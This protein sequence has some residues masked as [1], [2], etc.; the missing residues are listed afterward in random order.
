MALYRDLY[1]L[2]LEDEPQ[3]PVTS[4]TPRTKPQL[5][6]GG[7]V[8]KHEPA[9][10]KA[11]HGDEASRREQERDRMQIHHVGAGYYYPNNT[12]DKSVYWWDGNRFQMLDPQEASTTRERLVTGVPGYKGPPT[13]PSAAEKAVPA[14]YHI[15]S[16]ADGNFRQWGQGDDARVHER[17]TASVKEI[18]NYLNERAPSRNLEAAN[19]EQKVAN[20]LKTYLNIR[21]TTSQLSRNESID[22]LRESLAH[23]AEKYGIMRFGGEEKGGL[24]VA[25]YPDRRAALPMDIEDA[26]LHQPFGG[27]DSD[28]SV[29]IAGALETVYGMALP[30]TRKSGG[31]PQAKAYR[32]YVGG[33]Q[34]TEVVVGG[35]TEAQKKQ[36]D[37]EF[38]T[39]VVFG[40]EDHGPNRVAVIYHP[41]LLDKDDTPLAWPSVKKMPIYEHFHQMRLSQLRAK[42]G[43]KGTRFLTEDD[44][45]IQAE[46][47]TAEELLKKKLA[48]EKV[49]SIIGL[50]KSGK[51]TVYLPTTAAWVDATNSF[52]NLFGNLRA[53]HLCGPDIQDRIQ[54]FI[55]GTLVPFKFTKPYTDER[56][57]EWDDQ[58]VT[59]IL[60]MLDDDSH[61]RTARS[62]ITEHLS[63][64]RQMKLENLVAIPT[65]HDAK[66]DLLA[67]DGRAK[68]G[69]QHR[70]KGIDVQV[71]LDENVDMVERLSA[72]RVYDAVKAI[73][74]KVGLGAAN[75]GDNR[76]KSSVMRAVDFVKSDGKTGYLTAWEL[77]EK[78]LDFINGTYD[79]LWGYTP[80][81]QDARKKIDEFI[82]GVFGDTLLQ[83]TGF[84]P[85]AK[86]DPINPEPYLKERQSAIAAL[87]SSWNS[88]A[89]LVYN[90]LN[91][92]DAKPPLEPK[93]RVVGVDPDG[94][95]R[96]VR[97][98]MPTYRAYE[99]SYQD[100]MRHCDE[101]YQEAWGLYNEA[102]EAMT[103]ALD[104]TTVFQD[105]ALNAYEPRGG[106]IELDITGETPEWQKGSARKNHKRWV[107]T[108]TNGGLIDDEGTTPTVMK[109]NPKLI[110]D[111][112]SKLPVAQAKG[113]RGRK[114]KNKFLMRSGGPK[115][116]DTLLGET[117][118]TKIF[119]G[120]QYG[121]RNTQQDSPKASGLGPI[122]SRL[123][124]QNA[125]IRA[126]YRLF[127]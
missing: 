59:P 62:E 41:E 83:K 51:G 111:A 50:V 24:V 109:Q 6:R 126:S 53:I 67:I 127:V 66:D 49:Q 15:A 105:V 28:L 57:K 64:L 89:S 94:T 30:K 119:E 27:I 110:P 40:S 71:P 84:K 88:G 12:A 117:T 21:S 122:L 35:Q 60:D 82:W 14:P 36:A 101:Q 56:E 16:L 100:L 23:L 2:L 107:T 32:Y 106:M 55:E 52:K 97:E 120:T 108:T 121:K 78:S 79:D 75:S 46:K 63:F 76:V 112:A 11:Q 85:R 1:K 47:D 3:A 124:K 99:R 8:S 42:N 44:L 9:Y 90:V 116:L 104:E 91:K 68:L 102:L 65:S 74:V 43:Q 18:E 25:R 80:N 86:Y 5:A 77:R 13:V 95:E 4:P 115:I 70:P 96:T 48:S 69:Q 72:K 125:D 29:K 22:T 19:F 39:F 20:V 54:H 45:K 17:L 37:D 103:I 61:L 26:D 58:I 81:N 38:G 114:P 113:L 31:V 7:R 87:K 73:S 123:R 10:P 92:P 33:L 98:W 118:P 93:D 34:K